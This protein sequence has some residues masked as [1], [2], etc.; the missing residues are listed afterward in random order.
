[1]RAGRARWKI[2]N[3]TFNTLKNQGYHFEHNFGHGYINLTDVLAVLMLLAFL[4][5][6]SQAMSCR[7][8]QTAKKRLF[9]WLAFWERFRST[10][11]EFLIL[12][13]EDFY[14][15]LAY[16]HKEIILFPDTS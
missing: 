3:E 7:L 6:Q 12:S 1:M 14:Q 15:A 13:W 2:E 11:F 4:I 5:D 9:S 10:F 8:F 16:G